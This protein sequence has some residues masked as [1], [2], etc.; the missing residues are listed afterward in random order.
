MLVKFIKQQIRLP[1]TTLVC[2]EMLK[3]NFLFVYLLLLCEASERLL[4]FQVTLGPTP[5][6]LVQA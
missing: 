6:W 4:L 2:T 1:V 5:L 3:Y